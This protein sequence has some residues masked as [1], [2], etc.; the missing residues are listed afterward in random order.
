VALPSE[1]P[2]TGS[3]GSNETWLS[4]TPGV[5][6][7]LNLDQSNLIDL[8]DEI[9]YMPANVVSDETPLIINVA[10]EQGGS[11][12]FTPPTMQGLG[13]ST[14]HVIWNFPNASNVT[15][16]N[17]APAVGLAGTLF[18]P[19]ATVTSYADIKG[20]VIARDFVMYGGQ[21]SDQNAFSVDAG[22]FWG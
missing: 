5:A 15:V 13:Q 19:Y 18:A 8:Q 11:V 1:Y 10:T 2:G 21:L 22:I 17:A 4:L 3:A 16:Q 20:G 7:V 14:V 9:I 12:E 6:N